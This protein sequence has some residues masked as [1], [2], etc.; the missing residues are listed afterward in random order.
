MPLSLLLNIIKIFHKNFQ[1]SYVF[2]SDHTQMQLNFLF[3][4]LMLIY[5]YKFH[6]L[7]PKYYLIGNNKHSLKM[8]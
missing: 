2:L 5:F 4:E 8:Q 1:Q 7:F 6:T 3:D